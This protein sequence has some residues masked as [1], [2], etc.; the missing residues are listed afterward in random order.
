LL[1]L[2]SERWQPAK[3][4]RGGTGA[5]IFQKSYDGKAI[6]HEHTFTENINKAGQHFRNE[7]KFVKSISEEVV[8]VLKK[9]FGGK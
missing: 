8:N 9:L 4:R 7:D 2:L 5:M 1:F 3:H 6:P